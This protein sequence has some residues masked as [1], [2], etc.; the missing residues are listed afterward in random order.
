MVEGRI[1][2]FLAEITLLGQQ[3]VKDRDQTVEQMLKSKGAKVT[4]FTL[5]VVGE[6][7]QKREDDFGAEVAALVK[8]SA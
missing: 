4:R 8:G 6:G 1:N 2:K 7:I 3:F 5:Y